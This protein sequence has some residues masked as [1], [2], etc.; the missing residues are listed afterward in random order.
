[1]SKL[2]KILLVDDELDMRSIVRIILEDPSISIH[3]ATNGYDALDT[4]RQIAPDLILLD[5]MM[6]G[7][8]G[9]EV[10]AALRNEPTT[11]GIPIIMLTSRCQREDLEEAY[12][13]GVSAY[14]AK[15]FS[16]IELLQTVEGAL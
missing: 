5:W 14:L 9:V 13:N 1:M 12:D 4:A 10:A 8:T 6:P 11:A 15:P 7:I 2:K 16:P 3:E